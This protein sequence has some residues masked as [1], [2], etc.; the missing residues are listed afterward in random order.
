MSKRTAAIVLCL[1]L[2]ILLIGCGDVEPTVAPPVPSTTRPSPT[3]TPIRPTPSSTASP[4]SVLD[5][6]PEALAYLDEALNIMQE[7]SLNREQI[8]WE[9]LRGRARSRAMGASA[10]EDTYIAIQFALKDL[11]DHH[12]H[13]MTPVQVAEL[14]E[15]AVSLSR[16]DPNGKLLEEGLGYIML[17][18]FA[19][20]GDAANE[21]ATQIQDIIGEINAEGPCGWVVDLRQN[22]GGSMWPMLA[23]IGPILGEGQVGAFVSPDG[24]PVSWTYAEGQ[25]WEGDSLQ[26]AVVGAAYEL[27]HPS[28]PVAVLTGPRTSSSGEAIAVA[29]R[30]RPNTR[31]FGL[32][33]MGLSTANESYELSDGAW[34]FLAVSVFADRSGQLY[35]GTITPDEVV[36]KE[37]E[38]LTLQ[39]AVDWLME[40]AACADRSIEGRVLPTATTIP[41][42]TQALTAS[43]PAPTWTPI[44]PSTYDGLRVTHVFNAGFLITVGDRRILID[45][46]YA[47]YPEGILKPLVYNQPPFDGVDLVLATHE[48]HDHF[49]AELVGRYMKE[50]PQTLFVST[51]SAVDQLIALDG[52]LRQ[53]ATAVELGPGERAHFD[54]TGIGLEALYISHGTPGIHNLGFI[55]TV[56]GIKLFHT[57][58]ISPDHV[59]ISYLQDY[60][61][62]GMQ[63]DV[64]FVPDFWLTTEEYHA[65]PLE[66]IQPRY[67]IPMH[68]PLEDPPQGIE[69]DFPNAF[70]FHDMMESW[71]LP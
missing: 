51:R 25:A 9:R 19:G 42:A 53:R 45:A 39:T 20:L 60:G 31:S 28:P 41:S 29:F 26:S 62:P 18:G 11:G 3:A 63:I 12:S 5:L 10:P 49:S 15:G 2:P 38:E 57:G 40:Q 21:Y 1:L 48:H 8:D 71:V 30:G 47:G 34:I 61:L 65:H 17:P 52:K 54:I 50:N 16:P 36:G 32:A 27:G 58:D 7:H 6:S 24:E 67:I 35:G 43:P 22:T 37:E 55:I 69:D 68:F 23:G 59:T 70:V 33:T 66:G 13:F 4:T 64:A 14:E 44:A 46:L 56:D